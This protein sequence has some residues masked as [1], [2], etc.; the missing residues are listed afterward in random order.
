MTVSPKIIRFGKVLA[1]ES[2][3][4]P[5]INIIMMQMGH[6]N[7]WQ[8]ERIQVTVC[9]PS[10]MPLAYMFSKN[11]YLTILSWYH[12]FVFLFITAD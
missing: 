4:I 10:E 9:N 7:S 1:G 11:S 3:L 6:V 12:N 2:K 5:L 8:K